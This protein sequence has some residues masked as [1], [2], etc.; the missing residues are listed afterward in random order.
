MFFTFIAVPKVILVENL[1]LGKLIEAVVNTYL[2]LL[3]VLILSVLLIDSLA[4]FDSGKMLDQVE[5]K[6]AVENEIE[7]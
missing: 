4:F 2:F 7:D 1:W 5:L 6:I 3:V